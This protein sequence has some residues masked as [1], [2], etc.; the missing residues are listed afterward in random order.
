MREI[1]G[2]AWR[3]VWRN[4]RRS[5]ITMSAVVF[6]VLII[7]LTRSL[8]YGSYDAMESQAVRLYTG[9]IQIQRARFKEEQTFAYSLDGE[10]VWRE[11]LAD[12]PYVTSVSRRLTGF[13][14]ASSETSSAGALIVGIEPG[15]EGTVTDFSDR[16]DEGSGLEAGIA[17]E[18]VLGRVLARNL[19]VSIGDSVVVLTQGWQ[20]QMGAEIYAVRGLLK[21]GSLEMDRSVMVLTLE[22]AQ[23]LFS[24]ED[25]FTE[26]VVGTR[27]FRQAAEYA[28]RLEARIGDADVRVYDWDRLMPELRQ[29]IANI[30]DVEA[31]MGRVNPRRSSSARWNIP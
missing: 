30:R 19:A 5:L 16:V 17:G 20:N 11:A 13:G 15:L 31:S 23:M 29:M 18:V 28:R 14:L 26:V 1:L 3:N 4:R 24:M 2:L 21:T 12:A 6:S 10:T 25:R 8:Q 27:D 9:E 22:D 7:A